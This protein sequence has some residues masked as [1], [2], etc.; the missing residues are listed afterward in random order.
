MVEKIVPVADGFWNI[1]GSHRFKGVV[2]I[3]THASLVR[4]DDGRF[5]MLD[6]YTLPTP[7][8]KEVRQISGG[9]IDAIV[10]LHPF[11][12]IHVQKMHEQLPEARLFGTA[13]HIERQ[14]ELPWEKVRSEDPGLGEQF[15]DSIDFSVPAGVDF[16]SPDPNLHFSSVVARHRASKTIH[17]DD[18]LMFVSL[19]LVGGVSF[20]PT[21]GKVLHKRPGAVDEFRAWV[22]MIVQEWGDTQNLCAAHT[23]NLLARNNKGGPPIPERIRAALGDVKK[24]LNAHKKAWG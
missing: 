17:V 9:K 1:R 20:H 13:R 11:H 24:T 16:I 21:L 4:L 14:P 18:T 19:P 2:Q 10:N 6:A 7:I 8:L 12:T 15:A 5:V 23:A 3:G 22:E